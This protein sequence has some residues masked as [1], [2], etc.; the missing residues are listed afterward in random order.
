M[1]TA[2]ATGPTGRRAT[3][4]RPGFRRASRDGG[5]G[6]PGSS[7][8]HGRL[9]LLLVLIASY[10]LS[11]FNVSKVAEDIEILLFRPRCCLRFAPRR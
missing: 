6:P 10:L 5:G 8:V 2:P 9:G 1:A 7:D 11:A 4:A 3:T